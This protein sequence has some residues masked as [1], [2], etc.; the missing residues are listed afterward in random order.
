MNGMT[1]IYSAL[2][3]LIEDFY[4]LSHISTTFFD[5]ATLQPVIMSSGFGNE[6]CK[7]LWE[8]SDIRARCE[9]C[10]RAALQ[11][12]STNNQLYCYSCHA[13]LRECISPVFYN[14]TLL[15]HFMYGQMRSAEDTEENRKKR[16]ALYQ[17]FHL[18]PDEMEQLYQDTA[19]M[20][21]PQLTSVSHIMSSLAQHTFLSCMLGDNDA[22]LA[23]RLLLYIN[24]NH[25][26]A[27]TT[28]TACKFFG[29][30]KSKL[31]HT[32]QAELS[33]SFVK[34]VNQQ[35]VETVCLC[36]QKGMS[37]CESAAF[38][39][40]PSHN[41]MTRVFHQLTGMTPSQYAV[42]HRIPPKSDS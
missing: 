15:G 28:D 36:L 16:F 33:S 1:P 21:R 34:L 42:K 38:S 8:N 39:G 3:N 14:E 25:R 11:I 18:D 22:P 20:D 2:D 35:R 13:G 9:Q 29:I 7:R 31:Q 19:I 12:A 32:I 26:S 40:F 37:I 17:D 6:F 27:I 10:D 5:A 4:L 23:T 24:L 30:S 41:Y